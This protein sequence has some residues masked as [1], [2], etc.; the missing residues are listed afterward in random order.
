MSKTMSEI[1]KDIFLDGVVLCYLYD[2]ERQI[3]LPSV[4]HYSDGDF[5]WT[6]T[7]DYEYYVGGIEIFLTNSDFYYPETPTDMLF[8]LQI[9]Y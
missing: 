6:Q 9:L 8:V 7:I 1:T 5:L 4:R 3:M 2:N